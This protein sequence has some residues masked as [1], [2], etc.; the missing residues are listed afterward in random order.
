LRAMSRSV[1]MPATLP[2]SVTTTADIV[3]FHFRDR[4]P[5]GVLRTDGRHFGVE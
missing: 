2:F 4:R 3:M 1:R 5:H